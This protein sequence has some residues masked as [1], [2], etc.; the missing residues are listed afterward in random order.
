M[1]RW[2]VPAATRMLSLINDILDFS[3]IEAGKLELE[4]L[5][6]DIRD[7]L[8]DFSSMMAIRVQNKDVEFLCA[9]DP[10]V[11]SYLRGDPGRLRQVLVN[12]AGNASKFTERGEV[13][14]RVS[15]VSKNDEEAMLQFSVQ[16]TGIGIPADKLDQ[17]FQSF[18]QV[19]AS[20]T[21]K[22]GGTGLGLAISKQLVEK[23]GGQVGV[24]SEPGKGSEFWFT[25]HLLRQSEE[26][27]VRTMPTQIRGVRIL[28]VD[29]N[30][31]NREILTTRLAAWGAIVAESVDGPSALR[32]V[33]SMPGKPANHLKLSLPICKCPTWTA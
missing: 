26:G 5:D 30:A 21:R 24:S 14:V 23:M 29:D 22:Y 27:R 20:T 31:T 28:V 17:L 18:T 33:C 1:P 2:C 7:V 15:V 3:K 9:A 13:A 11:P 6:F 16:D 25:V 19:D 10:E 4:M 32:A 8:E 12:L